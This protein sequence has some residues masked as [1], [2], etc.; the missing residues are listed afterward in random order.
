MLGEE[1]FCGET[2]SRC[3]LRVWRDVDLE[4]GG[5]ALHAV[6]Q[7]LCCSYIYPVDSNAETGG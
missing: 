1:W 7:V 5:L 4:T 6:G 2:D 3:L